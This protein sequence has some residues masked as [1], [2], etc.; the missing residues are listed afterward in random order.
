MFA[1]EIG[2]GGTPIIDKAPLTM[3][4]TVKDIYNTEGFESFIC[5][6]DNTYVEDKLLTD[7]D[8]PDYNKLK[9]VLF[10]FPTYEYLR[11]GDVLGDC[12]SFKNKESEAL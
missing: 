7:T 2:E 12:L 6:I 8:K 10:Q 11:T 3:E 5:T 1:Y 4:C 9:P